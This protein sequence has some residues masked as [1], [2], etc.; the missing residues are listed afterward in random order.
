M[1]NN[2]GTNIATGVALVGAGASWLPMLK[3]VFSLAA[4]FVAIV[5]GLFVIYNHIQKCRKKPKGKK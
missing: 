1:E 3:D 2:M 5:C 4:S